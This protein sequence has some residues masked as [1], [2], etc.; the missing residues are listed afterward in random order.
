MARHRQLARRIVALA[1]RSLVALA[2]SLRDTM[3]VD[4]GSEDA[5][6]GDC[7]GDRIVTVDELIRSVRIALQLVGPE[8]CVAADID[9]D[10]RVT[11][12][13]IVLGV[14]A[15]LQ[16]CTPRAT[17]TA[18]PLIILP[19]N[20]ATP[21]ASPSATAT[22]LI[23]RQPCFTEVSREVGLD[24]VHYTVPS[25]APF[26]EQ[27][28]FSGGAAAGD[29]DGDG[30]V[31]LVV[32]RLD[33]PSLLLFR[34]RGDGSF[35]EVA[36]RAGLV[37]PETRMNGVA[38]GDIDND[39]DLDLYA[40]AVGPDQ[41]RHFLFVNDG[42][43]H[44]TEEGLARGA[45]VL[46]EEPHY[47]F[48]VAFGDYDRDGFLDIHVTE[49]RPRGY[50]RRNAP[51]HARLLRNEGLTRPGFFHDVTVGAG[52]RLDTVP[53]L[54]ADL[55]FGFSFAS[56]FTDLDE[57]GWPDLLVASDFGTSRLFWNRQD[58]TFLDGTVAAGVGTDENGMGS[59]VGDVDGDGLLDWFVSS[60]WDPLARCQG[61]EGCF[62]GT[63]GNRLFRNVGKRRFADVTDQ[64]GVRNAG[65]GWG[66]TFWDA[67]NDGDLDLV[68][69]NGAR[70][71]VLDELGMS[72]LDD[73]YER[74]R[75]RVWENVGGTMR[76]VGEAWGLIDDRQNRAVVVW[77]YDIDGDLDLF[78]AN[79]S[80]HPL[81]FRN[82]CGSRRKWLK[83][84]VTGTSWNRA[85]IGARARVWVHRGGVPQVRE[86]DGGSNY[87]GHNEF[88]AH[89]GLGDMTLVDRV[90]VSWPGTGARQVWLD[91]PANT[92]LHAVEP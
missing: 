70:F 15:L 18:T 49:W 27:F 79:N 61:P 30:R 82:D 46:T 25:P 58:G 89:F 12:E 56:R 59:A 69:G 47:G 41:R 28:Y 17:R 19:T 11:I 78:I 73:D 62:W 92:N 16:G 34:N 4:L 91:V 22:R 53:P 32:S 90:E 55:G 80:D 54:R 85:G 9:G 43:G 3:A 21:T 64:W 39:A 24:Y 10:R 76:E 6:V 71:P 75:L 37:V 48:S 38:W 66:A 8:A 84:K 57:D 33:E 31:D 50:N 7:D 51:S 35:E 83:I 26:Y 52:V 13:E 44:F 67:D 2:A 1:L 14:N 72:E 86:I 60:I 87:L 5:C 42:S 36:E 81:L 29:F 74:D 65:W 77:D 20:T 88:T 40:T 23:E 45:A 68:V 63:S